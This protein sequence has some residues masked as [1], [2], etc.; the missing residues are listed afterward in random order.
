MYNLAAKKM[1]DIYDWG[2]IIVSGLG[3]LLSAMHTGNL[4]TYTLWGLIGLLILCSI[5]LF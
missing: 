2:K 1:F 4:R 5:M 3:A